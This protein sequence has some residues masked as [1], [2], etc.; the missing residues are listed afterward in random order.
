[1]AVERAAAADL[2]G[3]AERF[4]IARLAQDAM[5]EFFAVPGKAWACR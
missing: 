1:M 4:D 2:D 5:I 3:V